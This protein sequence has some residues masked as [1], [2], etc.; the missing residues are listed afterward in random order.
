[1]LDIGLAKPTPG[2]ATEGSELE[3]QARTA[4]GTIVG[5]L[6]YMS[7]EQTQGKTVDARSDIFSLG[8]I[9]YEMLTG[10]R[11]FTGET[12]AEVL[13]SINKDA[14]PPV[15]E[16]RPQIPRA[17]SRIVQRC[18]VKDL[19]RRAQSAL[20]VR[21]ELEELKAE[22]GSGELEE[23]IP[24]GGRNRINRW[25]ALVTAMLSVALAATWVYIARAPE[26]TGASTH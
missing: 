3:T 6:N 2:F 16:S 18:L 1:M 4:E 9:F 8:I 15:T 26:Q 23:T 22:L 13:S 10:R 17:L 19:T 5:T 21:N 24:Q 14:P 25:F 7:P 12:P 20:D 11:P